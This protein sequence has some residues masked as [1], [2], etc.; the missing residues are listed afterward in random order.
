MNCATFILTASILAGP[1]KLFAQKDPTK[2][3]TSPGPGPGSARGSR[4]PRIESP[5]KHGLRAAGDGNR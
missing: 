4:R 2:T 5:P 3:C 1:V